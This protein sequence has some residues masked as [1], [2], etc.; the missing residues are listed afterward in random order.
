M[1][2]VTRVRALDPLTLGPALWLDDS[3]SDPSVWTD[4]SGNGYDASQGTTSAQPQIIANALNGRQ[5]RRFDGGDWL[6]A[7]TTSTWNFLHD[8]T[9]YDIFVACKIGVSENPDTVYRMLDTCGYVNTNIGF[10]FVYDDRTS[11]SRNNAIIHVVYRGVSPSPVLAVNMNAIPAN[12]FGILRLSADPLNAT[13]SERSLLSLNGGSEQKSNTSTAPTSTAD[14]AYPL[15]IGTVGGGA[16]INRFI[17]DIAEII[18]YPY[19]LNPYERQLVE[20]YLS[21]KYALPVA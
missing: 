13:S 8:G 21:Y 11:A 5:V 14:S 7:G 16:T 1:S 15:Y 20:G 2:V 17:G 4:K 3:G 9:K 18:I 6:T 19:A 12:S 10:S